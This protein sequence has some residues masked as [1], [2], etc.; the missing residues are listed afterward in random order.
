MGS[1]VKLR[2]VKVGEVTGIRFAGENLLAEL[3]FGFDKDYNIPV[4]SVAEIASDGL[5]GSKYVAIVPGESEHYLKNGE[6][7][8]Y[9][10]PSISLESLIAKFVFT[11]KDASD[12]K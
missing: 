5:M 11:P 3:T 10:Q 7:I 8:V 4:D 6:T 2:G 1:D 12:K 9:T